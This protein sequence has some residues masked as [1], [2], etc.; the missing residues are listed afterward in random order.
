MWEQQ[1]A[2][3]RLPS[4]YKTALAHVSSLSDDAMSSVIAAF[5]KIQPSVLDRDFPEKIAHK[6]QG[7][8]HEEGR[9]L[10]DALLSLYIL[11]SNSAKSVKEVS[12]DVTQT[13]ATDNAAD[14]FPN[15]QVAERFQDRLVKLLSIDAVEVCAKATGLRGE[16]EKIYGSARL[17]TDVRPIFG[18]DIDSSPIGVLVTHNLKIEFLESGQQREI[19]VAL[20]SK[21]VEELIEVLNRAKSKELTLKRILSS[22]GLNVLDSN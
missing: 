8:S 18:D 12:L 4:R 10:L 20:D 7:I 13:L 11:K 22:C 2:Y 14:F 6:V 21:D 15:Q 9:T 3:L 17:L 1:M 19:F 16:Y 5:E